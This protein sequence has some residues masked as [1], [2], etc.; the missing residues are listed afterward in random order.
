MILQ[1][2]E[3]WKH[4]RDPAKAAFHKFLQLFQKFGFY[5]TNFSFFCIRILLLL[6]VKYFFSTNVYV[7]GSLNPKTFQKIFLYIGN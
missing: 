7:I 3:T 1:L 2:P 4:I 5:K 6:V